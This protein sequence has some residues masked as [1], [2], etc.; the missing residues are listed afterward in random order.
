MFPWPGLLAPFFVVDFALDAAGAIFGF[1]G[2]G[3]SSEKDS[4]AASSR[5]TVADISVLIPSDGG[6]V[7][8]KIPFL[9]FDRLFLHNPPPASPAS[10]FHRHG[11]LW[12]LSRL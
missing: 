7:R 5:V 3:S 12:L 4:Q 1:L 9:V 10:I 2:G 6:R 11:L 8:T